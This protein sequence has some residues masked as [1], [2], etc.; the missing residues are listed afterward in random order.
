MQRVACR[1]TRCGPGGGF[2]CYCP[3]PWPRNIWTQ[4][5]GFCPPLHP[6][7]LEPGLMGGGGAYVQ[8]SPWSAGHP[9]QGLWC[10]RPCAGGAC[11]QG[12]CA[13]YPWS[14][15]VRPWGL[16][17]LCP[18]PRDNWAQG[19]RNYPPLPPSGPEPGS[20]GPGGWQGWCQRYQ[21]G[22]RV[23]LSHPGSAVEL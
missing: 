2:V 17:S 11:S 1:W 10:C 13:K 5:L 16:L 4:G 19:L 14:L 8:Y 7:G 18:W 23:M 22:M 9:A 20:L 6:P 15:Y 3:R 12:S 21:G